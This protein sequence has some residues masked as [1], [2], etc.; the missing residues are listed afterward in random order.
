MASGGHGLVRSG[1]VSGCLPKVCTARLLSL[2]IEV[3]GV[4]TNQTSQVPCC[5]ST[6]TCIKDVRERAKSCWEGD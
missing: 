4:M 1:I 3:V 6:G 5:G 2:M